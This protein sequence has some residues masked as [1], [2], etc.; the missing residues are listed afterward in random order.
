MAKNV[1]N[2]STNLEEIAKALQK[3]VEDIRS[4]VK[5]GAE[6]LAIQTHAKVLELA[7]QELKG[8]HLEQYIG[9]N[10]E[11]V[12]WKKA[13][14]NLWIVAL[15]PK[16]AYIEDGSEPRPMAT[17]DWLLKNAKT[18]K[19]GDKYKV[20]PMPQAKGGKSLSGTN[21]ALNSMA[22]KVIRDSKTSMRTIERDASGAPKI[23]IVKKL[24]PQAPMTQAQAPSLFSR[25][26][27]PDEAA[28]S[29]LK[30][31]QGIFKLQ[32]L[33][34][35]QKAGNNG[36]VKKEALTFRVVSSKHSAENRWVYP[37]VPAANI[38]QKTNDWMLKE[39]WPAILK[40]ISAKYS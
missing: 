19:T 28:K 1:F 7:S 34:I 22:K 10:G 30:A 3:R 15:D 20:I 35:A 36:K 16:A 17:D 23:G 38:F 18:S 25:P 37:R 40:S 27:T 31:H 9:R 29:G 33:V 32:G 8:Y 12:T 2:F 39:A 14:D 4:D 6:S 24:N 13:T 11:N 5:A 21:A 26:R